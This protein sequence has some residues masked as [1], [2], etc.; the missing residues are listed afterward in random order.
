MI[1]PPFESRPTQYTWPVENGLKLLEEA[2]NTYNASTDDGLDNDEAHAL[3]RSS[4]AQAASAFNWLEGSEY[5]DRAHAVLHDLGGKVYE[6]FWETCTLTW[7]GAGYQHTCPVRV[8]H[9]RLGFS[10]G[11]IVKKRICMLCGEDPSECEHLPDHEYKVPGGK[12]PTGLCRVCGSS[13]C[14]THIPEE[15]YW[16][17]RTVMIAE[18][19]FD[20]I[21]LV[22]RPRQPDA[23]MLAVSID[24]DSLREAIGAEFTPGMTVYCH[25]CTLPCEGVESFDNIRHRSTGQGTQSPNG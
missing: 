2:L 17:R 1:D 19:E 15:M 16:A 23:R 9:K 11:M 6:R 4:L 14:T 10:P 22:G 8:A 18:L 24:T 20:H 12:G 13:E 5:E 21:A 25:Q 7:T 3:A